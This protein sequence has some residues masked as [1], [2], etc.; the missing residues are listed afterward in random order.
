MVSYVKRDDF[1]MVNPYSNYG[2]SNIWPR[3][4]RI[5][6]LGKQTTNNFHLANSSNIYIKPLIFQGLIDNIP[7]IDSI[8]YITRLKYKKEQNFNFLK[9]YPILYFPNNY[10]PINAKNTRYLYE[11]FPLLML[12]ISL[13]EEIADILRGYIIQYFAWKMGGAVIY[14]NSNV[15]KDKKIVTKF[16]FNNKKNNYSQMDRILEYLINDSDI[17][18]KDSLSSYINFLETL[19]KKKIIEKIDFNIYI[20]FLKDLIN[21]GFNFSYFSFKKQ[22]LKYKISKYLKIKT[23]FNLYIPSNKSIVKDGN[24]Q[25][26]NHLSSNKVYNDTLLIINFNSKGYLNL[27]SC[28]INIY[29]KFFPNILFI[30]PSETNE[31]NTII[32]NESYNGYYSYICFLKVYSRYP[33]YKGYLYINDDLFLKYWEMNYFNLSIPWLNQF[34]KLDKNWFHYSRCYSLYN[35]LYSSNKWFNNIIKFN[36]FF[37]VIFAMSDF[38]Y[39]PQYYASK[40]CDIFDKM[41]NYKLF[42]ECTIPTSFAL[43]LAS[44]YQIINIEA[45]WGKQ[46][47]KAINFLYSRDDQITVHPIKLSNKTALKKVY[48]YIYFINAKEY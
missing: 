48:Q 20:A 41:F 40:I 21:I 9:S 8:F 14:Y 39:L 12:P 29:N 43:L 18:N 38:Y 6:D 17:D 26:I 7:D 22:K 25:I 46:R 27:K 3:G 31:S 24:L 2:L 33:N 30:Y 35:L 15:Y 37:D 44:N 4:F 5:K 1:L 11:I 28:L 47:E 13:D 36:G 23:R 32:C 42:L 10:I 45:L 34:E 16:Y 19:T